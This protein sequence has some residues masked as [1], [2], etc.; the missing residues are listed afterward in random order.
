MP[1]S[2]LFWLFHFDAIH[3]RGQLTTYLR[4]MGG[5]VPS[6]YGHSADA[7]SGQH[8]G[9]A[10]MKT[11]Y[12]AMQVSQPGTFT[13]VDLPVVEPR[14]GQVRIAVEAAGICHSDSFVAEG[15]W[16]GLSYPRVPGHEVAGRIDKVGADVEGWNIGDRV[17][18]GW[19]GGNCALCEPCRRGD[20]VNCANLIVTGI[21]VDGGYGEMVIA[22]ARALARVPEELSAA[23]AAPLLC[24]GVTTFN[25]LRNSQLRPGNVVAIHGIGGLGHLAVQYARNMGFH[26]VAIARG[27]DKEALARKLGAHDYIDSA[28]EDV[29]AALQKLGGADA[30][31]TTVSSGRAMGPLFGGLSNRGKFI[32]VGSSNEPL[33]VPLHQLLVGSKTISG[34]VVGTA[35][36]ED[37]TLDFSVL[38]NI[39]P[40]IETVSLEDVPQAYARMMRNEARFRIV[41]KMSPLQ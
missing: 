40:M 2:D 26:T 19:F 28:S 37:D 10:Y 15:A 38:Q 20:L 14:A 24:A 31:L 12:R 6:T 22:E 41:I 25:A 35:V 17:A 32:V 5:T 30:I 9:V 18:V 13:L 7:A 33:E 21:S 1:R 29:V 3:H 16:P 23:E 27:A 11:T 34:E 8:L 36:D 4:P 39:R